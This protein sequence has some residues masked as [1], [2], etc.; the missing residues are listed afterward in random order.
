MEDIHAENFILTIEK[1]KILPMDIDKD[2]LKENFNPQHTRENED[3]SKPNKVNNNINNN[4]N[5]DNHPKVDKKITQLVSSRIFEL[6]CFRLIN[7]IIYLEAKNSN[8]VSLHKGV[9]LNLPN[10]KFIDLRG[11]K[12]TSISGNFEYLKQLKSLKLDNNLIS[13]IPE[14]IAKIDSLEI[15]SISHNKISDIQL[16]FTNFTKLKTLNLSYNKI[17]ILPLELGKCITLETLVI[18]GNL[19][20]KIPCSLGYLSNLKELSLEWF[21]FFSKPQNKTIRCIVELSNDTHQNIYNNTCGINNEIKA[22]EEDMLFNTCE[23]NYNAKI[24]AVKFGLGGFRKIYD[25]TNY[26][27]LDN[28]SY[29]NKDGISKLISYYMLYTNMLIY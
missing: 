13:N 9:F 15:L 18:E 11:N 4:N 26:D 23:M 27:L 2:D 8:I 21:E 7:E 29:I 25:N 20:S 3:N 17:G 5:H 24:N 14:A 19:F 12:L 6:K 10:L 16:S 28:D 1:I 22:S